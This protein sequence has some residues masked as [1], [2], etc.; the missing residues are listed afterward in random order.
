MPAQATAPLD[1]AFKTLSAK[2]INPAGGMVPVLDSR[3]HRR[4][5]TEIPVRWSVDAQGVGGDGVLLDISVTG[6]RLRIAQRLQWTAGA[7]FALSASD[8]PMLPPE[9]RLRWFRC[10]DR[11][12]S[13]FLCG[14][15]F[16]EHVNANTWADWL[17]SELRPELPH[18]AAPSVSSL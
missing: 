16:S 6:A 2:P 15:L 13:L 5:A 17:A 4:S 9:A 3:K 1:V 18:P 7:T 11:R 10:L 14:L 12:N 8:V